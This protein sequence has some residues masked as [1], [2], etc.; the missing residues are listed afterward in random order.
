MNSGLKIIVCMKQVYDPDSPPS[1]FRIDSG[2]RKVIPEGVPPV[3]SPFDE[4]ALEAALRMKETY[5]GTITVV[6]MG[7]APSKRILDQAVAAGADDLVLLQD[8]AFEDLDS[9]TTSYTLAT[10]I[11]KRGPF[12]LI[13]CGGQAADSNSGQVGF[14]IA[15]FLDIPCIALAERFEF[16]ERTLKLTSVVPDGF[17]EVEVT[18]PALV[19]IDS[20]LFSLRYPT[21]PALRA[22]QKK[23]A[24]IMNAQDVGI[25]AASLKKTDLA[26]LSIRTSSTTCQLI[27]GATMDEAGRKLALALINAKVV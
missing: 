2:G 21:V 18:P 16:A 26:G 23:P 22:A 13:F 17:E 27:S 19:T 9:Y 5:G 7:K 6:S 10:A 14:G 11:R 3:I 4:N 15:E 8:D 20:E 12:D 1:A 25:E 24:T